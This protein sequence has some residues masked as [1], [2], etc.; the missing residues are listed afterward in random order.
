VASGSPRSAEKAVRELETV[1]M[2]M[3][4]PSYTVGTQ[5]TRMEASKMTITL[6]NSLFW[7]TLK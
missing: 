1:L 5:N 7:S 4:E 6:P 3:P 2:R